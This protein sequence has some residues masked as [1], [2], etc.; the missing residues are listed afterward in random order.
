MKKRF[1]SVA[2][3]LALAVSAPL[4]VGCSDYDDDIANLQSQVDGLKQSVD[5]STAEALQ[6]LRDAQSAMQ[7]DINDLTSGKADAPAVEQLQST[8]ADLQTAISNGDLSQVEDLAGQIS[9]LIEQVN[10]I[11][12]SLD[13]TKTDLETQRNELQ[14][15]IDDLQSKLDKAVED[16]EAAIGSDESDGTIAELQG[17]VDD[18]K[19]DLQAAT[20]SMVSVSNRLVEVEGWLENNGEELAKLTANVTK[21]NNLI[22]TI[23]EDAATT[24]SD[25]AILAEIKTLPATVQSLEALQQQIGSA[26]TAGS[27]L[28]RLAEIEEWKNTIVSELLNGTGY[29]SFADICQKINDLELTLNGSEDQEDPDAVVGIQ[30]QMDAIRAEMA[31]FDM[32]QSVV[33]LPNLSSIEDGHLL[34]TSVLKVYNK[35]AG[36]D[37]KYM[38][39][40]Q[41]VNANRIRFRVSPASKAV[42]FTGENPKYALTFDGEQLKKSFGAVMVDG[43]GFF[44]G[45]ADEAA[46]IVTYKVTTKMEDNAVWAVCAVIKAVTPEEG[47]AVDKTDLTTTYFTATKYTDRVRSIT[48]TS[49]NGAETSLPY[50]NPDGTSSSLNYGEGRKVIGY[51]ED[52]TEIVS[53]MEA[54]YGV[55][56]VEYELSTASI[57][58]QENWFSIDANGVLTIPNASNAMIGRQVTVTPVANFGDFKME[59][60]DAFA[61][62]T[63]ARR[64]VEHQVAATKTIMWDQDDQ[65]IPLSTEEMD[66]IIKATELSRGDFNVLITESAPSTK[67]SA[68]T[69]VTGAT[70]TNDWG[71]TGET[72]DD[73]TIYI[74]VPEKYNIN[75]AG[76]LSI[77]LRESATGSSTTQTDSYTIKVNYNAMTYPVSEI[78]KN[79]VR[80]NEDGATIEFRPQIN[81]ASGT[82]DIVQSM[83]NVFDAKDL[84]ANYADLEAKAS[85][86]GFKIVVDPSDVTGVTEDAND[87][88]LTYDRATYKGE[89]VKYTIYL[90]Y[91]NKHIAETTCNISV[92]DLS[93][94]WTNPTNMAVAVD[95]LT[96]TY[97]IAEGAKWVDVNGF[98]MW[99]NGK[100]VETGQDSED[101]WLS[102]FNADPF[103]SAVYGMEKPTFDIVNDNGDV[104]TD[105]YV[106]VNADGIVS[107]TDEAK[108]VT[109]A[110][111]YTV[112]IRITAESPWGTVTNM[113]AKADNP[114]L[115]YVDLTLTINQGAK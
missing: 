27:I 43:N 70:V 98:T 66:E 80:W 76:D 14:G 78:E 90:D 1:I 86:Y 35:D 111:A 60:S 38:E 31:K 104:I 30:A 44:D 61:T 26:T 56:T 75:E 36:G 110:Q 67:P 52:G 55:P 34:S 39:V 24:I 105:K 73:N 97:N 51:D 50:L 18:I 16:L 93:G 95:D 46:G 6:A 62:V 87:H 89:N 91:N 42:D 20:D 22:N 94:E 107:F 112:K 32:I 53:D 88:T 64:V 29:E 4:W 48:V 33:Y 7:D 77:T 63:V 28:Y 3:F 71:V 37:D 113:T 85:Q 57:A 12:G 40:A 99:E 45:D 83:D 47:E 79:P 101:N 21:I 13:G 41:N 59:S 25:A 2:M 92:R 68:P 23:S 96:K 74:F 15:Q 11:E 10:G 106:T 84:F 114:R 103:S 82:T 100:T 108:Q 5:V 109:F 58:G 65:Y 69:L 8:V 19:T 102:H 54:K 9:G 17:E 49:T 115:S 72:S 81:W